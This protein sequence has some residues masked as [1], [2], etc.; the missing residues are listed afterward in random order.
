MIKDV[1]GHGKTNH[2]DHIRACEAR[3]TSADD[4]NIH[5]GLSPAV[6]AVSR[7]QYVHINYI[8]LISVASWLA[9][10]QQSTDNNDLPLCNRLQQRRVNCSDNQ[11]SLRFHLFF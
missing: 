4:Y 10:Q 3:G 5:I 7:S 6:S 8:Q 9:S 11:R 2:E 1:N